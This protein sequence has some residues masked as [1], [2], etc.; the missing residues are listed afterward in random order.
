MKY[1]DI[2]Q[3][4]NDGSYQVNQPWD[5]LEDWIARH[6]KGNFGQLDLDPDFQ[7][8]HV[9]TE[10][11]QIAYV[12]FCLRG[13]KHSNILRFNCVGWMND[14]RGPFVLVDGKQRL[15]A[16]RKFLRNELP[17]F[18]HQ[19]VKGDGFTIRQFEDK[20]GWRY[21]FIIVVN[22]LDT[23]KKVLQWYLDINAGGVVHTTEELER[24]RDLLSQE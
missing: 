21:D 6:S 7:R 18:G 14:F 13:G 17:V 22:N 1:S 9:W 2:S 12:E 20:M 8:A 5:A 19:L 4:T 3:F 16:V 15:E 10:K 11:Q 24:V 23:R